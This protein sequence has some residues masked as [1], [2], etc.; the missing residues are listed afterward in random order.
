MQSSEDPT[1]WYGRSFQLLVQKLESNR[2]VRSLL[3]LAQ[4][5][6]RN[7]PVTM[8]LILIAFVLLW[9]LRGR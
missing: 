1:P 2:S 8:V 3:S 9:E 7:W 4:G 5:L 6:E